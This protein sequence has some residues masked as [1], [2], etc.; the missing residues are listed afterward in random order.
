MGTMWV[1]GVLS[2]R[3]SIFP[4]LFV[5]RCLTCSLHLAEYSTLPGC[6]LLRVAVS[7]FKFPNGWMFCIFLT[8]AG[9]VDIR[10][11]FTST[12]PAWLEDNRM[13]T[14]GPTMITPWLFHTTIRWTPIQTISFDD[15]P[16]S[17]CSELPDHTRYSQTTLPAP[18][19]V[20]L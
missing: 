17:R 10:T 20:R 8:C 6:P 9:L 16:H 7:P 1:L 11:S 19:P 3:R 2:S 13:L 15:S 12:V 14:L 4:K 18:S 5:I